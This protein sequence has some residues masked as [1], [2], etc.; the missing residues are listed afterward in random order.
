M[1]LSDDLNDLIE[2]AQTDGKLSEKERQVIIK[3][4][5]NE[6]HDKDEFEIYLEGKIQEHNINN[7]RP[8]GLIKFFK[9]AFGTSTRIVISLN[10]LIWVV[11]PILVYVPEIIYNT[12]DVSQKGCSSVEDCLTQYKFEEARSFSNRESDNFKIL[13]AEISYFLL[14][15]NLE[16][17][18]RS[19]TEFDYFISSC[20]QIARASGNDE[21]N[22]DALEYNKLIQTMLPYY[23]DDKIKLAIL[24]NS[25][26]PKCITENPTGAKDS[27]DNDIYRYSEN[28]DL[29]DSLLKKYN[30]K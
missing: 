29:R 13:K 7:K 27:W 25:I 4:A 10:V 19:F 12:I 15:G 1:K 8:N 28:N 22:E 30:L 17:P 2:S 20:E 11:L 6:G 14:E 16:L 3:K 26:Y 24:I 5:I 21:Y 18:Y 9:F 23:E